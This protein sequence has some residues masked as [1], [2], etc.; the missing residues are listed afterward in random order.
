VERLQAKVLVDFLVPQD[1]FR[2]ALLREYGIVE[3]G[4]AAGFI[5]SLSKEGLAREPG[6]SLVESALTGR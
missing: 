5:Q 6:S 4:L 1:R 2:H 3:C